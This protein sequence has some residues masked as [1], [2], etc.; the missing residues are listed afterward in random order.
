MPLSL[1]AALASPLLPARNPEKPLTGQSTAWG[2]EAGC[3]TADATAKKIGDD[4]ENGRMR[5][6]ERLGR[7]PDY[8]LK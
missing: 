7:Q 5:F 3:I 8:T 6:H 2:G 4:D 1:L